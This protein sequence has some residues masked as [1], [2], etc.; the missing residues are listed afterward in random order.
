MRAETPLID[1]S[2]PALVDSCQESA[3]R[4]NDCNSMATTTLPTATASTN[5]HGNHAHHRVWPGRPYPLG[6]TWDGRSVNFAIY[7]EN[8]TRVELCLYD[9]AESTTESRKIDLPEQ[10]DQVW[11]VYLPDCRPGQVYGYR[12]HGPYEPA[13]GHRFNPNKVVLDPYA[14]EIGRVAHWAD[15]MFGL[16][17]GRS[18]GGPLV[19]RA[20]QRGVG[21]VGR[22]SSTRPLPG[23]TI[24]LRAGPC[25]RR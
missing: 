13:K 16:Q 21:S 11:H 9:N 25:T 12:F 1:S 4:E 14:K 3:C 10:T 22:R 2:T 19:R 24:A 15:E 8:A 6:A 5:N 7:S 23:G 18:A 17:G 20:R